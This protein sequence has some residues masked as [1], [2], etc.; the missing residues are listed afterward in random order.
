MLLLPKFLGAGFGAVWPGPKPALLM[1]RMEQSG[2]DTGANYF[3]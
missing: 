2:I 3:D 1:C